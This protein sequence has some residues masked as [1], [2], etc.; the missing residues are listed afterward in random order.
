MPC[1][2][3]QKSQRGATRLATALF[4]AFYGSFA[5]ADECSELTARQP[6]L[7]ADRAGVRGFRGRA[8]GGII[9]AGNPRGFTFAAEDGASFTDTRHQLVEHILIHHLNPFFTSSR[10]WLVCAS[11]RSSCRLFE[12]TTRSKMILRQL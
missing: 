8:V 6:K 3:A 10:S 11:L 5:H 9:E 1:G 2:D 4:P 12:Y 7:F